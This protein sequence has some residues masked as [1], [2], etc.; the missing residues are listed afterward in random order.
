MR[1]HLIERLRIAFGLTQAQA[2][3][4]ASLAYG[5]GVQHD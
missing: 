5:E 3:L 2:A 1:Q 4:V